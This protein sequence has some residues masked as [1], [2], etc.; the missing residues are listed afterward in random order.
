MSIIKRRKAEK[1]NFF[2]SGAM[3]DLAFLLIVFFIV[4]A[5][6]NINNG[7]MMGLP[8]KNSKKFVKTE[9]IVKVSMT[10]DNMFEYK[11][12]KI[13]LDS[14]EEIIETT[15]ETRPNMTFLLT[16]HPKTTYQYVVSVVDVIRKHD[17][18]N[19]SFNMVGVKT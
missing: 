11:G 17:V 8:Q 5:T 14:V 13:D 3:S 18:E 7:F 6:F 2:D 15:L 10:A 4:I 16:I 12:Q 9:D 1:I 19:F